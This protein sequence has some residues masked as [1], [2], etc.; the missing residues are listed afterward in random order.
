MEALES[1]PCH[2]RRGSST[3]QAL[4]WSE[5]LQS[6]PARREARPSPGPH[7]VAAAHALPQLVLGCLVLGAVEVAQ[8][9]HGGR[10]QL[11]RRLWGSGSRGR[12]GVGAS[13]AEAAQHA[14]AAAWSTLAWQLHHAR[15]LPAHLGFRWGRRRRCRLPLLRRR[16][17][18]RGGRRH[19]RRALG[20]CVKHAHPL[21]AR[22]PA[23]VSPAAVGHIFRRR[24]RLGRRR[25]RVADAALGAVW[26]AQHPLVRVVRGVAA[27]V[28]PA[29]GGGPVRKR[30]DVQA[31]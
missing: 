21:R 30:G 23:G 16:H 6:T 15:R 28:R 1:A 31:R 5:A 3:G 20:S 7:L 24:A 8:Q 11:L 10:R 2:P 9:L 29:R 18:R 25:Q 12:S 13:T 19:A 22:H 26:V 17:A 27:R 14:A 4:Q